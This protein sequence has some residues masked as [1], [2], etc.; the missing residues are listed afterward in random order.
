MWTCKAGGLHR[1]GMDRAKSFKEFLFLL[2]YIDIISVPY[3]LRHA[4][5][6][7][8]R[9]LPVTLTTYIHASGVA[10]EYSQLYSP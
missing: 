9:H 6:N 5:D 8:V 10:R 4:R 2:L 1:P 3:Y 7:D